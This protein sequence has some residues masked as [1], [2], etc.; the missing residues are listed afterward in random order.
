MALIKFV[1]FF[2]FK[3]FNPVPIKASS[4]FE[5]YEIAHVCNNFCN[6]L[7]FTLPLKTI[8]SRIKKQYFVPQ[9]KV[10]SK[11]LN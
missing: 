11:M 2:N 7:S 4:I 1:P 5:K 6:Y 9:F 3:V 10:I 8:V